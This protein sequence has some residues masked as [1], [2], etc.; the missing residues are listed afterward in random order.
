MK[1]VEVVVETLKIRA[2]HTAEIYQREKLLVIDD[3]PSDLSLCE[4]QISN[5]PLSNRYEVITAK[6]CDEA[7]ELCKTNTFICCISDY[8]LQIDTGMDFLRRMRRL[9]S[10]KYTPVIIMTGQG[11]ERLAAEIM[12]NGAQDYLVKDDLSSESLNR[13]ISNAIHTSEL[14]SKLRH[15]A[16]YDNLTGLL[17]R[18]LF[19]DRVK[20]TLELCDRHQHSCSILYIDVDNFKHIN[21]NYGHEAGDILLQ[22]VAKRIQANCR[23]TDSPARLGG[24]EFAILLTH[25]NAEDTQTTAAKILEKVSQPIQLKSQSFE[26]SLSIGIAHYPDTAR[27]M[28]E[29]M[30]QADE[31]MYKAKKGGK[32]NYYQFTPQQRE[33]WDR[34]KNLEKMLPKAIDNGDLKLAF[35]PII[36]ADDKGLQSLE[37]LS[38]WH[39]MDENVPAL[40]L[41]SMIERLGLFDSFHQWLLSTAFEQLKKWQTSCDNLQLALNI[42]A[43][44]CHSQLVMQALQS[45][46]TN[47]SVNPEQIE[48]E[49][50]ETT[51]MK[52]PEIS[53]ELLLNMQREGVKVA[54]DDFGTGYSSMAYLTTLPLNTLK[55]DQGFFTDIENNIRNRK[56]VEAITAL[57]HSL[58]LKVVA[59]GVENAKQYEFAKSI[60]CDY[61]QGYFF[62]KP[63]LGSDDWQDFIKQFPDSFNLINNSK[64]ITKLKFT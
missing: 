40:E 23:A 27:D 32:A 58:G 1:Q 34:R 54:V 60:G 12:R 16:H 55:I 6:S 53:T 52:H 7:L 25:I 26:I 4:Q 37:V 24:D 49:I 63:V 15:L 51:L 17:N 20:V 13:S 8:H 14:Q 38:R 9:V 57:G 62:A 48:L 50:T 41:M 39:A 46:R 18:S 45:L 31:A 61:L 3:N 43:N 59:E 2:S 33:E 21:D 56:V 36:N 64:N 28:Q 47:Y 19:M 35:Q 22:K 10:E 5:S 29:L 11:D 42:P 30:S 44:Q